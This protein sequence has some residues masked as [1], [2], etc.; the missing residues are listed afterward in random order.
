MIKTILQDGEHDAKITELYTD[1]QKVNNTQKMPRKPP[2]DPINEKKL[3]LTN[4]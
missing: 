1:T 2:N 4:I 3:H